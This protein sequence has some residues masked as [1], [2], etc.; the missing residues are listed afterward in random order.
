[1]TFGAGGHSRALLEVCPDITIFC[2]DRDPQAMTF[3]AELSASFKGK[4]FP[5]LG[6][7]SDSE[8]LLT[9]S[10]CPKGGVD[11]VVMDLGASSMQFD[12]PD[13]GFGLSRD[14][15]LDM[16]MSASSKSNE[17][18]AAD[19]VNCLTA[20]QLA[21]IFKAYGEERFARRIANAIVEHRSALGPIRRTGQLADLIASVVSAVTSSPKSGMKAE[22]DN[23]QLPCPP[24]M[25]VATRV[26]QALRIFVNDE[27]NELCCGLEIAHTFLKAGGRVAVISFHSLEDRLVKWAF[28]N[29]LSSSAAGGLASRLA[30]T[31][32]EA[33]GSARFQRLLNQLQPQSEVIVNSPTPP[34]LKTA[35]WSQVNVRSCLDN[36]GLTTHQP[37]SPLTYPIG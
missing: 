26:F 9:R 34:P 7:F 25:H 4:V 23:P 6:K 5:V 35:F 12:I 37:L 21:H 29:S 8:S 13:R 2:L 19:V 31:S 15:L 1:M 24:P 20:A 27:L 30:S 36:C 18:T 11:G 17:P 14:S 22:A 10:G 32:N 33:V 28:T 16:R 3:A